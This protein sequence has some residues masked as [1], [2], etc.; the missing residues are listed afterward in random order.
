MFQDLFQDFEPQLLNHILQMS[1]KPLRKKTK[2]LFFSKLWQHQSCELG[3]C[4]LSNMDM[5]GRQ[6]LHWLG[7]WPPPAPTPVNMKK[8][9]TKKKCRWLLTGMP[10]CSRWVEFES[11]SDYTTRAERCFCLLRFTSSSSVKCSLLHKNT[12][13]RTVLCF[14]LGSKHMYTYMQILHFLWNMLTHS[15]MPSKPQ[16]SLW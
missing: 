2:F 16:S 8:T 14:I 3:E 15:D 6:W 1:S 4:W 10:V 7:F 13:S 11:C 12:N 9:L 5:R